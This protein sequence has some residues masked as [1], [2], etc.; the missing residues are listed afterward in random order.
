MPKS[1]FENLLCISDYSASQIICHIMGTGR[2]KEVKCHGFNAVQS[3]RPT[4]DREEG[5]PLADVS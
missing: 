1:S 4:L 3:Y 2:K 5:M